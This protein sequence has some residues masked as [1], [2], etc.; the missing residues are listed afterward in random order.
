MNKITMESK[1]KA[2]NINSIY[3]LDSYFVWPPRGIYYPTFRLKKSATAFF[4]TREEAEEAMKTMLKHRDLYCR[5]L[6]ELPVGVNFHYGESFSDRI[7][8]PDGQLWSERPYAYMF[9]DDIPFPYSEIEYDNYVYGRWFFQ[10]RKAQ[11]IRFKPGDI[12]EVF[13]YE[14][15]H[16]WS[17]GY[18]EL[19][20]VLDTPPTEDEMNAKAEHYFKT[21]QHLTGDKGFD[22]G[23]Q[24]NYHDDVYAIV[25]AIG[26]VDPDANPVDFCPTYCAM[27]PSMEKVSAKM[28]NKLE[29]LREKVMANE[30][31]KKKFMRRKP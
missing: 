10:G 26:N 31:W 3:R 24:F 16:Y 7:Y 28:R 22:L 21:S 8:L 5:V 27:M 9:P 4:Y 19:A 14:G 23:V 15:N 13:G 6:S 29:G 11:E 20:I 1:N 17:A 25:A 2:V 12:I 30:E 18:G